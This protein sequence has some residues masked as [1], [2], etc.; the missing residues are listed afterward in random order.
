MKNKMITLPSGEASDLIEGYIRKNNLKPHDRLLSEREMCQRWGIS[1]STL[2]SA[3]QWM[4]EEG[5]LYTK[6]GSGT[7]VAPEKLSF[8]LRKHSTMRQSAF[9]ASKKFETK[10]SQ[11]KVI[12]STARISKV[13]EVPIGTELLYI[14]RLRL[15]ESVPTIVENAYVRLDQFSGLEELDFERLS[16]NATLQQMTGKV[17]S[18]NQVVI[19]IHYPSKEEADLLGIEEKEPVYEMAGLM[20]DENNQKVQVVIAR[21]RTDVFEYT[22]TYDFEE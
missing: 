17:F 3:I 15:I 13:L 21:A 22:S 7:Y 6:V 12:E 9:E 11:Q 2:R 8:N 5:K 20:F 4:V 18:R 10:L 19:G 14:Q 16:L 1:R